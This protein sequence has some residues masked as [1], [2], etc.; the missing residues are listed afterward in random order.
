MTPQKNSATAN[1]PET[2]IRAER[3]RRVHTAKNAFKTSF[4]AGPTRAKAADTNVLALPRMRRSIRCKAR[5]LN[6]AHTR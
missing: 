2:S 1:P 3:T 5:S 4:Q 6:K